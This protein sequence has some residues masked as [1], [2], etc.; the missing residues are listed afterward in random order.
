VERKTGSGKKCSLSSSKVLTALK[1][2]TV[3]CSAKS[4]REL[5]Q[6]I[7]IHQNSVKKYLTKMVVHR[8]AKKSAPKTTAQ[9]KVEVH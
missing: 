9:K 5:G 4:Y 8:K 3:G 1:K 2:Q 7:Q 6:K